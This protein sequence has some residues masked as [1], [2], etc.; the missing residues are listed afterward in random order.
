MQ[1]GVLVRACVQAQ[2]AVRELT[3]TLDHVPVQQVP[4]QLCYQHKSLTATLGL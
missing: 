1:L 2:M 3:Q 4:L